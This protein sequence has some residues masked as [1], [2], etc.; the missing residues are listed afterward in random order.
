MSNPTRQEIIDA[1]QTLRYLCDCLE[2]EWKIGVTTIKDSKSVIEKAL[3]PK[4]RPTMA[5]VEWDEDEHFLAEAETPDLGKVAMLRK[6]E[7]GLIEFLMKPYTALTK[8]CAW[9]EYFTPTGERYTLTEV[10]E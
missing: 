3:P 6:T 7:S 9:P 10:Q 1:H 5:E 4:P 2:A 8:S